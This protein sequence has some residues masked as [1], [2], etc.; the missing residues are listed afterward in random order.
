MMSVGDYEWMSTSVHVSEGE[1]LIRNKNIPPIISIPQKN[2]FYK[3][4]EKQN[5]TKK[6]IKNRNRE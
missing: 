2:T 4:S 1:K 3:S 6:K 5:K